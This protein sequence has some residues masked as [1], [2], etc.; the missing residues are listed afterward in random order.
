MQIEYTK[1]ILGFEKSLK[2]LNRDNAITTTFFT[3]IIHF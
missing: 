1:C 2:G 3:K